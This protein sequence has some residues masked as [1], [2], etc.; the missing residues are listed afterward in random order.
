MGVEARLVL[1]AESEPAAADAAALAYQ[2][3]ADLDDVMSDYRR[4]SELMRLCDHAGQGP[5]P[6]SADLLDVLGLSIHVADLSSG[7][8]DPT[9]GP[10]VTL[11]RQARR[12]GAMPPPEELD[13]ARGL[14]DYRLITI[15]ADAGTV[16]LEQP[17]MRLDLGGIGKG[18]AADEAIEAL[19]S[20][21][22]T[23]CLVDLGGDLTLAD[24]PPGRSAWTVSV[25]HGDGS[26]LKLD[27]ANVGVATSGDTVQF[28]EIDGVRYSHIVDPR[29]G[30]GLTNRTAVTVVA[31]TGATADALASAVSVLGS[32]AGIEMIEDLA[33][34]E[35]YVSTPAPRSR[36]TSSGFA[37]YMTPG[38]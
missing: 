36:V 35:C 12:D 33:D 22:I 4:D 25:R 16:D 18:Y 21:G 5:Q 19:R 28:V 8:F 14:I 27:V 30:L 13:R 37:A 11:W 6:A 23:S 20:K 2:R 15:D 3:M 34:T 29:T 24:P 26:D 31:P 10:A 9:V 1:Y 38:Q 17:G 7:A 32:K